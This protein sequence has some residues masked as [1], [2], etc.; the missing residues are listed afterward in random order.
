MHFQIAPDARH[1]LVK[2][3]GMNNLGGCMKKV[4][5]KSK[6]TLQNEKPLTDRPASVYS[7]SKS[8]YNL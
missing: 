6:E 7:N 3:N 1:D 5:I 8:L 2:E 4:I